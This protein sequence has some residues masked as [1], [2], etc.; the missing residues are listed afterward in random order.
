MNVHGR[1]PDA[2][3]HYTAHCTE[4]ARCPCVRPGKWLELPQS[5]CY[6]GEGLWGRGRNLQSGLVQGDT[7]DPGDIPEHLCGGTYGR[8]SRKRRK[9]G[10]ARETLSYAEKRQRRILKKFGAGGQALGADDSVKVKLEGGITKKSKP[11][12]AGSAR[13]RDLR[14]AAALARFE[15]TA[16]ENATVKSE[17]PCN[18]F[19]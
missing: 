17:M 8:R 12:V 10:N 6:T 15:A 16:K 13:G 3:P 1:T 19:L 18:C 7:V 2:E 11:R 9:G 14:A 4:D 5:I